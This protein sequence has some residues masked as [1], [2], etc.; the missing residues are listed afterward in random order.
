MRTPADADAG[1]HRR[2]LLLEIARCGVVPD[3]F[4]P[5]GAE[6]P[7]API[8]RWQG[9]PRLENQQV[10][11]PWNGQIDR[12]PILFI[13]SNP[14]FNPGEDYPLWLGGNDDDVNSFFTDRFDHATG[15]WP[16]FWNSMRKLA[17][18]LLED[19][20]RPGIDFASTEVVHC[21]SPN[22]QGVRSALL[23]CPGP[24]P[25]SGPC[26]GGRSGHDRSRSACREAVRD[27]LGVGSGESLVASARLGDRALEFAMLPHPSS[28]VRMPRSLAR[29]VSA[30][31]LQ[32]RGL[33]SPA[34]GSAERAPLGLTGVIEDPE[35]VKRPPPAPS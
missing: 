15:H 22:E 25:S 31:F 32:R 7:C 11:E 18:E 17:R 26:G 20:V 6:H 4:R 23:H 12:A 35:A 21:K 13:S 2:A 34:D 33:C 10:P 19:E 29:L 8:V 27:E 14:S 30:G 28:F 5:E 1:A 24:L 3:C 9:A 16:P